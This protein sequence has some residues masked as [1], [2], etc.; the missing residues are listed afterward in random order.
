MLTARRNVCKGAFPAATGPG[1]TLTLADTIADFEQGLDKISLTDVD[2]TAKSS[3]NQAFKF[4]DVGAF[5]GVAGQLRIAHNAADP[6]TIYGDVNGDK[7][8]DFQIDLIGYH[9]LQATDLYL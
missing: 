1:R 3:G 7:L 4:I 8:A 5:S 6:T 2:A 9:P